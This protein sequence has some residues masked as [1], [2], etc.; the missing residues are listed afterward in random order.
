[1]KIIINEKGT[2]LDE[3]SIQDIL[4]FPDRKEIV[5]KI[6]PL[7]PA[8]YTKRDFKKG[9]I[10]GEEFILYQG[11]QKILS[12]SKGEICGWKKRLN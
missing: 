5:T 7:R 12:K 8:L 11:I 9:D 3:I 10:I 2:S 4:V 6:E 1:M